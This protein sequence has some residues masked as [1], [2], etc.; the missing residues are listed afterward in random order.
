M[1]YFDISEKVFTFSS[2]LVDISLDIEFCLESFIFQYFNDVIPLFSL[3]VVFNRKSVDFCYCFP[4][5]NMLF[6]LD[7]FRIV[8]L[9]LMFSCLAMISIDMVFF[10]FILLKIHWDSWILNLLNQRQCMS[11]TKLG[12]FLSVISLDFFLPYSLSFTSET[13]STL[14]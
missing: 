11:L 13:P 3:S 2:F 8:F 1:L 5:S 7:A 6:S 4:V 14:Y 10:V 9:L 12:D